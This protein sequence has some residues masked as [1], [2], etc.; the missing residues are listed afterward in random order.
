MTHLLHF[1]TRV[2]S[3]ELTYN[4]INDGHSEARNIVDR[5]T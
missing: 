1:N 3:K 4:F 5:V 2:G